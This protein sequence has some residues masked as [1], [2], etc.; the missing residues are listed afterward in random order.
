MRI[1]AISGLES[2]AAATFKRRRSPQRVSQVLLDRR[3]IYILPTGHGLAFAGVL[4]VIL[5]GAANY[6]NA[7]A[8]M[9]CFLLGSIVL[10]SILHSY[11][12]LVGLRVSA[13]PGKPVFAGSAARFEL[14]IENRAQSQRPA[15]Q[16]QVLQ[17]PA[18]GP[19]PSTTNA[20]VP[21]NDSLTLEL[22]APTHRRGWHTLGR[23]R[24]LTTHPLG[25][26][27]AWSVPN[28]D[29]RVLIYP[30]PLGNQPLPQ[31]ATQSPQEGLAK[32]RGE[33]D[34]SGLKDYTPGD[35][36]RRVHWKAAA[37]ADVLAVKQFTGTAPEHLDLRW[38]DVAALDPETK[39]SQLCRWVVEADTSQRCFGLNIPGKT[40][41]PATGLEHLERCLAALAL[42][43]SDAHTDHA[44]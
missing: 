20:C 11:R 30:A 16:V 15:L 43:D 27:R 29:T 22:V 13:K 28:L 6:D 24:I 4:A 8:Y 32:G 44:V 23:T 31:S 37:R 2:I 1:G 35:S 19:A 14:H 25:F 42:W 41:L 12:N 17:N 5:L 7:L 33:E 39:L 18:A 3:R 40:V 9:L 38:Q 26:F 21:A 36:P 10:V 34:F